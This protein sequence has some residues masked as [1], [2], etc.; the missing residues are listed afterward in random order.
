MGEEQEEEEKEEEEE[1][2]EG[3]TKERHSQQKIILSRDL[4]VDGQVSL[5]RTWRPRRPCSHCRRRR[6]R[7][8]P[9]LPGC[10][11]LRGASAA[12][13]CRKIPAARRWPL[14]P[15]LTACASAWN[16]SSSVRARRAEGSS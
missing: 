14:A 6:T 12:Q 9:T 2:E 13:R 8:V 11:A 10:K 5:G 7:A 1:E 3:R 4:R 15:S 16:L